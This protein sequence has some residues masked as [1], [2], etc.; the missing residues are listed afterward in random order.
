MFQTQ[1]ISIDEMRSS[2]SNEYINKCQHL[3]ER[4]NLTMQ[5]ERSQHTTALNP[6]TLIGK[7]LFRGVLW[8]GEKSTGSM[9]DLEVDRHFRYSL[10]RKLKNI[11]MSQLTS[12]S[13]KY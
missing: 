10:E 3:S 6:A 4:V 11:Y 9:L 1:S 7:I 13:N 8:T 12:L 5:L 2:N